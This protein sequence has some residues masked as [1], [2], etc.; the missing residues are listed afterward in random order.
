MKLYSEEQLL[1]NF[2]SSVIADI[3]LVGYKIK[4]L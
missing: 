3:F 4:L 1:K 2:Y